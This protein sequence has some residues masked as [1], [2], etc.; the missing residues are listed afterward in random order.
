MNNMLPVQQDSELRA[1]RHA[2]GCESYR[3]ISMVTLFINLLLTMFMMESVFADRPGAF[4]NS[5][6]LLSALGAGLGILTCLLVALASIPLGLV[7]TLVWALKGSASGNA[8]V[9]LALHSLAAFAFVG[10]LMPR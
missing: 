6:A 8:Y 4:V 1:T 9:V 7:S 5:E 10:L 3:K 2:V